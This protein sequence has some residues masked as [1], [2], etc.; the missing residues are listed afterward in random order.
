MK[1]NEGILTA[2]RGGSALRPYLGAGLAF[3]D[4]ACAETLRASELSG[5]F[6]TWLV[7]RSIM[8]APPS[9]HEA[10]AGM[11]SLAA[12][13]QSRAGSGL[14]ADTL[15]TRL[16]RIVAAARVRVGV[17]MSGLVAKPVDDRFLNSTVF[18]GRVER[19]SEKI[20]IWRPTPKATD[21]LS[22][23]VL[24]LFAADALAHREEYD[25]SLCVCGVCGRIAI[26]QGTAER[27][28]CHLHQ[29]RD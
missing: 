18:A 15:E 24:S 13:A 6:S 25:S 20:A 1:A 14:V 7:S 9:V 21:Q 26:L 10:G 23:I 3:V 2:A 16:A 19:M 27:R 12:I 11:V 22:D 29:R 28:R 17:V 5:W 8:A 4:A